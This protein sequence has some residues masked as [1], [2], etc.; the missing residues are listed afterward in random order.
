MVRNYTSFVLDVV[1]RRFVGPR[2]VQGS[3][4]PSFMSGNLQ[5]EKA[6][7]IEEIKAINP[8][9]KRLKIIYGP[10]KLKAANV[11]INISQLRPVTKDEQSTEKVGN[12]K[13]MDS[14]G[15][16]YQYMVDDDFPKDVTVLEGF[17]ATY[18]ENMKRAETKDG[19][20]NTS[21]DFHG[22]CLLIATLVP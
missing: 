15:T 2:Q 8:G 17:S 16:S 6:Y 20:R 12:S 19:V 13:S 3:P 10:Y 14:G 5:K 9:A 1:N 18:D 22:Q 21:D 4:R 11:C 7:K